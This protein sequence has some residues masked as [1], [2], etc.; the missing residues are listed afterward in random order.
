[1][2]ALLEWVRPLQS[3]PLR[4]WLTA[5]TATV[6]TVLVIGVPTDLIDTALFSRDVPPAWWAWPVL[7][8]TASLTGLLVGTY[9]GNA[10]EGAKG[11]SASPR[12]GGLGGL[13]SFLAVGCPA[14]NKLVLFAIGSNGALRWF[15]P[16]QP[17]LS[18][19]GLLLLGRALLAR[20]RSASA[21]PTPRS[22]RRSN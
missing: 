13:L 21:C 18:I 22:I 6:G 7:G 9:V 15:Q 20:L 12:A 16:L 17:M 1:M 2:I 5:A 3:W 4:G 19:A 10:A 8:L 11:S 14:C